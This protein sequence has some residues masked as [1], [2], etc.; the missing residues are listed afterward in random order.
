MEGGLRFTVL[1]STIDK[2]M[3]YHGF[4]ELGLKDCTDRDLVISGFKRNLETIPICVGFFRVG[5]ALF[6][7]GGKSCTRFKRTLEPTNR[8]WSALPPPDG[9]FCESW[10]LCPATMKVK[11]SVPILVPL[12]DGRIFICGGT[13]EQEGWAEFYDPE[14]GEFEGKNLLVSMGCPHPISCFQWTDQVVMVYYHHGGKG[15]H[16]P[17][18]PSLLSYNI[19]EDKWDKFEENLPPPLYDMGKRNLVYVGG[20]ILFIIDYACLWFVYDLSSRKEVGEVCVKARPRGELVPVMEAFY[21]GNKDVKS[22]SWVFYIFMAMPDDNYCDLEYA[23][24]E[25]VQ[26]KG[27][28]YIATVQTK[29]VLKVGPFY[30]IYIFAEKDKKGK[31]KMDG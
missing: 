15:L 10:T 1:W 7:V 13:S 12:R 19:V 20:D 25:V 2:T 18:K 9:S 28:D 4:D 26:A 29:G 23:K 31:E 21:A 5:D 3:H 17:C 24:V 30:D 22:T 6:M 16:K 14:K 8:L 27:G 11:R